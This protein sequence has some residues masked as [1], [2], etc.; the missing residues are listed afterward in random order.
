MI[1]YYGTLEKGTISNRYAVFLNKSIIHACR[2]SLNLSK[3][4]ESQ[5]SMQLKPI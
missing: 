5:N 3:E 4:I 1:G 2:I